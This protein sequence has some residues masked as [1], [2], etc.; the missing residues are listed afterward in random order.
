[1]EIY[2]PVSGGMLTEARKY[3]EVNGNDP[4]KLM[5]SGQEINMGE[6]IC[7]YM[8]LKKSNIKKRRYANKSSTLRE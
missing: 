3:L 7:F 8:E 6:L 2:D 5:L 4:N 1:M